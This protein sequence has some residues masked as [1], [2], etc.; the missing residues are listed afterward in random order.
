MSRLLATALVVGVLGI[1][2]SCGVDTPE[3]VAEPGVGDIA[4]TEAAN[5][6]VIPVDPTDGGLRAH[7]ATKVLDVGKQ[8]IAFLLVTEK[9]LVKAPHAEISVVH[10]DGAAPPTQV[11]ASFN[12]W[13]YGVRGSYS[14]AI[15]FPTAGNYLLTASVDD[16]DVVGEV[17]IPLEVVADSPVPSLGDA[18]P[19]SV[20]KTLADG[21]DLTQLT[22]AYTPDPEL[23]QLSIAD[24]VADSKPDVIVFASP[25]F[26]TSP[27]CGPQV[28]TVSELRVAHPDAANYI[29]VELYDNPAEIQGD[30]S[31]AKLVGTADE[32][33][34]TKIDDWTNESWVFVVD[35]D[36]VIRHRFEGFA[37]LS[38]LEAA[39]ADVG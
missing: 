6:Q 25:A 32:W 7:L 12:E 27:T 17:V 3:S 33:G 9:A 35:S 10:A 14:A 31:K 15:D 20:T 37:T 2:I 21:L 23:Y 5:I 19:P 18:T 13:P 16:T 28:D 36:G 11:T 22:T 1:A 4:P 39:L 34:F 24:A 8:R 38:E 29:H 26:C 30:L